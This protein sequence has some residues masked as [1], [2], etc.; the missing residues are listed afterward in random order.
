MVELD[1]IKY[2][3]KEALRRTQALSDISQKP[4][5]QSFGGEAWSKLTSLIRAVDHL[6]SHLKGG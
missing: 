5:V 1:V 3:L 4:E 2:F 6:E